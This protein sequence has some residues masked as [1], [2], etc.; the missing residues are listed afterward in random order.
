MTI[1]IKLRRDRLVIQMPPGGDIAALTREANRV[2]ARIEERQAQVDAV[3]Q[4]PD[5]KGQSI[6]NLGNLKDIE[7]LI[8]LADSTVPASWADVK[9]EIDLVIGKVNECVATINSI[10]GNLT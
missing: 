4:N 7:A 9:T 2:L 10:L 3:G 6:I 8:V 5:M 1:G